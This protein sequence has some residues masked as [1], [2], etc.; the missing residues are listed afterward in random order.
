MKLINGVPVLHLILL[1][2]CLLAFQARPAS[3]G[4]ST[5]IVHMDKSHMPNTFASHHHWYSTTVDSIKSA[6]HTTSTGHQSKPELVY[7]YDNAFHGFSALLSQDELETLKNSPGF[8]SAYSDREVTL[9]TT[10]SLDFLSLNP[11]SGL[12]P[13]SDFGKDVI[14]G[15]V[16]TGVWPE[17]KSFNDKGMT[18]V[19]SRWKGKCDEGQEFNSSLCNLKLIGARYFNK[20]IIAANPNITISTNSARDTQGHGTHTS[21][22][23]AGNYVEGASYFGYANGIAK[24][25]APSARVAMYKVIFDEGRYSSDVLA[26]MD[27]A[28]A[29]GVD[30]ISI[31]MGFDEVPLYKDPIAIASFGAMEKGVVV[32]SSAGNAG[33]SLGQLHNGIPWVLTVAA[34]SID[35]WFAGT[36]TLGNGLTITGWSMFPA[37]ALVLD[38][39]LIYNKTLS[40][41][42]STALLSEAPNRGILICDGTGTFYSQ[43]DTVSQSNVAAAIFISDDPEVHEFNDFYIPGVVIRSKD[44]TAVIKYAE[45]GNR[46]TASMKFQQTIVGTK[47]APAVASYTSRGPSPSYPGILKPDVMAPGTLVLASWIPNGP[48][49]AIGSNIV[50]SGDYNIVSGTSMSCPHASGIAALL[51]GAHPEWSPAAIRS[52]MMT[53]ANPFDNTHN[54]IRDTGLNFQI[55][56]PLAMGAGQVVPNQALDPGLIYDAT[57]QDY[58]NLLCSMNFTKN[59]I[60][61]ITRS[62]SYG[63]SGPSS[64]L[65]YPSFIALYTNE[66]GI[67]VQKFPRTVT[68]VGNATATY[69]AKVEAPKGSVVTVSPN[70]L[71]FEKMYEKKSYSLTIRYMSDKNRTVTFGS[72]I[73]VEISGKHSVRSPIVVSPIINVW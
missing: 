56:S 60:F 26:G 45:S 10:H 18:P 32:S 65:N 59:Q 6:G 61:T 1:A 13:A 67:L 36:L 48:A 51:K 37:N 17:S 35:R 43:L 57:P 54:P 27:Q 7:T 40:P 62:H 11:F 41:C 19:P 64:D 28:V 5:Y 42:N 14:I 44:A 4:R 71:A 16:D 9:D 12:W 24:G 49:S 66:T 20:G 73:W 53:T 30:V 23:A 22:T 15:V 21:S 58:V 68:N 55:A 50:L 25:V 70:T 63:C 31:S 47:P 39:P 8:V 33:A 69:I 72:I 29:D 46:S 52:A 2:W 38:L 34:G 3:V